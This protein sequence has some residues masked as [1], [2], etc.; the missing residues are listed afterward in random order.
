MTTPPPSVPSPPTTRI[1]VACLGVLLLGYAA[2]HV[3]WVASNEQLIKFDV[4]H[5]LDEYADYRNLADSIGEHVEGVGARLKERVKLLN[6]R[7]GQHLMWPRLMYAVGSAWEAVF[8]KGIKAPLYANLVFVAVLVLGAW[9]VMRR[10]GRGVDPALGLA[11]GEGTLIALGL[12]LFYPGSFGPLR[13]YGQYAPLGCCAVGVLALLMASRGFSRRWIVLGLG[14]AAG[15]TML[16]KPLLPFYLLLPALYVLFL[17]LWRPP[18]DGVA[19]DGRLRRLGY[20]AGA[21]VIAA[22]LTHVWLAGRVLAVIQESAAHLVP[23]WELF[24]DGVPNPHSEDYPAWS[25]AWLSYQLRAGIAGLGP[26]GCLGL[27]AGLG[28]MIWRRKALGS[29]AR[30]DRILLVLAAFGAP[31]ILTVV[32]SKEAR[33]L[34]PVY[35]FVALVSALGLMALPALWRRLAAGGL[36][37]LGISTMLG[38]SYS[39]SLD[40]GVQ[41]WCW[42]HLGDEEGDLWAGVPGERRFPGLRESEK[43]ALDR[44]GQ[45]EPLR[46]AYFAVPQ[47][48]DRMDARIDWV[49]EHAVRTKVGLGCVT[50]D[51]NPF[52]ALEAREPLCHLETIDLR[53]Y[54][55]GYLASATFDMIV[56]FHYPEAFDQF[57]PPYETRAGESMPEIA[58]SRTA[59]ELDGFME[60]AGL[61]RVES[62]S[63]HQDAFEQ[64]VDVY[65][66]VDLDRPPEDP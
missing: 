52:M 11:A 35:P 27:V 13:L 30:H 49:R 44:L 2:V 46:I 61:G 6:V 24:A 66:Y 5:H 15:A 57:D 28:A 1:V 36:A 65:I 48:D 19:G 10:L 47:G 26:A 60:P 38:L 53:F 62:R 51:W 14:F 41:R 18:Q 16:I 3:H 37:V 39:P 31:L 45:G 55:P 21:A 34:F 40:D 25:L 64:P 23:S 50:E 33:F 59:E 17:A 20:A 63:Y 8:G 29:D 22:A 58:Y 4:V 43:A 56:V 54:D 32:S 42:E 9:G 12:G 7:A